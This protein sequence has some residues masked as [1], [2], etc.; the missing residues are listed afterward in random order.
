M[1]TDLLSIVYRHAIPVGTDTHTND[2]ATALESKT[3]T[4]NWN[5][6][7]NDPELHLAG[8]K[9]TNLRVRI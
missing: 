2:H 4:R 5:W 8:L 9:M 7:Q 1:Q 3:E 6:V